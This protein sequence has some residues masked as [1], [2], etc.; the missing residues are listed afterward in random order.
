METDRGRCYLTGLAW[1]GARLHDNRE[2][3]EDLRGV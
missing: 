1:F 3:K 2:A